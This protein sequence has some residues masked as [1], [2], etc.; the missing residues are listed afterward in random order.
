MFVEEYKEKQHE[1]IKK[2]YEQN[3]EKMKAGQRETIQCNIC[4]IFILK[5]NL[6]FHQETQICKNKTLLT[7]MTDE[8]NQKRETNNMNI[9]RGIMKRTKIKL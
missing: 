6:N 2:N 8:E 1:Y 5:R 9:I 3:K 7:T 4:N